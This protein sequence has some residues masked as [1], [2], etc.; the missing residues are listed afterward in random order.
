[1]ILT[2]L[3]I[4]IHML[5]AAAVEGIDS[6]I[7]QP[8]TINGPIKLQNGKTIFFENYELLT[9]FSS[10][11]VE[12]EYTVVGNGNDSTVVTGCALICEIHKCSGLYNQGTKC[13]TGNQIETQEMES[14]ITVYKGN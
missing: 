1:M 11:Y 6:K 12:T 4:L 5:T 3:G 9:S 14:Q 2:K 13:K 10:L 8:L 7:Y